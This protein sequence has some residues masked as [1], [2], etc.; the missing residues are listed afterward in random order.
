MQDITP[1]TLI[2]AAEHQVSCDVD[3]EAAL[4]NLE[5]GVYYGLD[6]VGA[7]LWKLLASPVTVQTLQTALVDNFDVTE[8]VARRDLLGFLAEMKSAGLVELLPSES[9]AV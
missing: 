2:V 5:T 1:A 7:F 6:P 9:G 4:L 3:N 8:A